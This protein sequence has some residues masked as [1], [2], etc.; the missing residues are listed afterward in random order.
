MTPFYK[1][2]HTILKFPIKL[3]WNIRVVGKE[4]IEINFASL[5]EEGAAALISL[6]EESRRFSEMMRMYNIGSGNDSFSMPANEALTINTDNP[7]IKKLISEGI[8]DEVK[9]D[10]AKHVYLSAILLSR[11]LTAEEAKEFVKLNNKL[12]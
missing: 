11:T 4:N 10:I 6:S 9:S 2:F 12:I 5:G 8:A 3:I 1:F 7:V